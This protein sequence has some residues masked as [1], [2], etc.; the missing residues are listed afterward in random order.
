VFAS[1]SDFHLISFARVLPFQ[2]QDPLVDDR[3]LLYAEEAHLADRTDETRQ[4]VVEAYGRCGLL[5]AEDVANLNSI[6]DFFEGDFFDLMGLVYA[7]AKMF[8]CALRWYREYIKELETQNSNL[9]SDSASVYA[10]VG[11]ALYSLGLFEETIAWSKA[12]IGPR[13]M[14]DTVSRALIAYEARAVGGALRTVQRSGPRVRYTISTFDRDYPGQIT[15]R[16]KSAM[17][18]FAPFQD[19]YFDWIASDALAAERWPFGYP[20]AA[21]FDG[22]PLARHKMNLIL[23]SCGRADAL[24]EKGYVQEAKRLL[25]E[26]AMI[27]PD[28]DCVRERIKSLP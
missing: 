2:P 7:N 10:S 28:A 4:R 16:L 11:Y 6:I 27:E 19:V 20:F 8:R 21:E 1:F 14:A 3:Q 12:C 22:G 23:A 9:E 26:V 25:H 24:V 5:P 17:K 18:E 13:L 15:L